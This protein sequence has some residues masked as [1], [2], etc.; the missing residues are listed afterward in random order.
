VPID[1]IIRVSFQSSV[2]ANQDTNKALV[3][4]PQ[5]KKGPG[6]FRKV[7]TALYHCREGDDARVLKSLADLGRVLRSHS[8]RV[9]FA[10]ITLI[11]R[12]ERKPAAPSGAP[13]TTTTKPS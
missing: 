1:A 9:D 2:E 5:G 6:P 12:P 11:R 13:S 4:R 7:N 10:S 3:G 8:S